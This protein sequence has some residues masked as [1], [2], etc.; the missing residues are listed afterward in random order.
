MTLTA[1]LELHEPSDRRERAR[2]SSGAPFELEAVVEASTPEIITEVK[3]Q[4]CI[5][6]TELYVI[7]RSLIQ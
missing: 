3:C 4:V 7:L 5:S 2:P 6:S 1:E